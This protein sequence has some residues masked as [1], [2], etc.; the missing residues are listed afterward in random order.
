MNARRKISSTFRNQKRRFAKPAE[1]DTKERKDIRLYLETADRSEW[2]N[3]LPLGI[4]HGINTNPLLLQQAGISHTAPT[5]PEL[6]DLVRT[7]VDTYEVNEIFIQAWGTTKE[8][9]VRTGLNARMFDRHVVVALPF[10]FE[11]TQAAAELI[12]RGAS[13]CMANSHAQKQALL[14]SALQADYFSPC[15]SSI[16]ESGEDAIEQ[17]MQMQ[18]A[19]SGVNSEI[20]IMAASLKSADEV[21]ELAKA[22]IKTFSVSPQVAYELAYQPLTT[23]EADECERITQGLMVESKQ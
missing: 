10:T 16:N 5:Y 1:R 21:V 14:A 8:E 22:G 12:E 7:A 4:F 15:I 18:K 17:C 2:A 19:L 9:L 23:K 13:V 20:R 11:G 3:L 6:R